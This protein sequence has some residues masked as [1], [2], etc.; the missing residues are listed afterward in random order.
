MCKQRWLNVQNRYWEQMKQ[1]RAVGRANLSASCTTGSALEQYGL[2]S[3][4]IKLKI[5]NIS[6]LTLTDLVHRN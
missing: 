1:S 3:V 6:P 5:K 4:R 2:D